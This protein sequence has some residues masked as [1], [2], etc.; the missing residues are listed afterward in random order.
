MPKFI[1]EINPWLRNTEL[2]NVM[3]VAPSLSH[4]KDSSKKVNYI[5]IQR[6]S[7]I[8]NSKNKVFQSPT[9][10]RT[11]IETIIVVSVVLKFRPQTRQVQFILYFIKLSQKCPLLY[12]LPLF[13]SLFISLS[14]FFPSPLSLFLSH[15]FWCNSMGDLMDVGANATDAKGRML[16]KS[17]KMLMI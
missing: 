1:Y 5:I 9:K 14:R 4:V 17:K 3:R 10:K 16:F 11:F 8:V 13:F 12:C 15:C 7:Q 6:A 2:Q